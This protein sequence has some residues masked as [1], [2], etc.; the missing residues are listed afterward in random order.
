MRLMFV[1]HSNRI[2]PS[3]KWNV[4]YTRNYTTTPAAAPFFAPLFLVRCTAMIYY[5]S[6]TTFTHVQ[7]NQLEWQMLN[8]E[9]RLPSSPF[10]CTPPRNHIIYALLFIQHTFCCFV[11][12]SPGAGFGICKFRITHFSSFPRKHSGML[13]LF[14]WMQNV[15]D[16]HD[17]RG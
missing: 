1:L 10:C 6:G 15:C 13:L 8:M 11:V 17:F 4:G 2:T 9:K 12:V 3:D 14:G 5:V 7:Q 16:E